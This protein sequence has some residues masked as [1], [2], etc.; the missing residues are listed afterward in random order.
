MQR[1][2]CGRYGFKPHVT[3]IDN[4]SQ[5]F[6][7]CDLYTRSSVARNT[8]NSNK[9]LASSLSMIF[10]WAIMISTR[11]IEAIFRLCFRSTQSLCCVGNH[12]TRHEVIKYKQVRTQS[13]LSFRLVIYIKYV[14]VEIRLEDDFSKT[15]LIYFD[16]QKSRFDILSHYFKFIRQLK[17]FTSIC[18]QFS[19]CLVFQFSSLQYEK[20][21]ICLDGN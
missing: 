5:F 3:K 2:R 17:F 16:A 18:R 20:G 13:W 12:S 4:I 14:F 6:F 7:K 9:M 8:I 15:N 21:Q 11:L 1:S 10:T 19:P